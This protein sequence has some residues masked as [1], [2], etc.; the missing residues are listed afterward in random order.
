MDSHRNTL[1]LMHF[2]FTHLEETWS[3]ALNALIK[4]RLLDRVCIVDIV[5]CFRIIL[6]AGADVNAKDFDG[7]TPLHA[8]AHWAQEEACKILVENFCNF[9]AKNNSVRR[10]RR[11][12]TSRCLFEIISI[13]PF[14]L[15]S[16]SFKVCEFLIFWLINLFVVSGKHYYYV[17]Q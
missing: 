9:E 15:L 12:R 6:E 4:D 5:L 8:A 7:W 16:S 11:M 10:R 3:V 13:L 1:Y 17:M 14:V 2:I